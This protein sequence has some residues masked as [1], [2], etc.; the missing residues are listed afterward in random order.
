MNAL[1]SD[2]PDLPSDR[3]VD[4]SGK[5]PRGLRF[6]DLVVS[7]DPFYSRV[8][9]YEAGFPDRLQPC[10]SNKKT[11]VLRVPVVSGRFCVRPSQP[12]MTWKIRGILKDGIEL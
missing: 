8:Y 3:L 5:L 2:S 11:S 12:R 9:I 4:L 10:C 7:V 1:D 6:L